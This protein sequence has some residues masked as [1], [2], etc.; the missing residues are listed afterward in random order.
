M[1]NGPQLSMGAAPA[2]FVSIT[3]IARRNRG[4]AAEAGYP[5]PVCHGALG[6]LEI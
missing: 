6:A 4:G 1:G 3:L 5:S 2:T